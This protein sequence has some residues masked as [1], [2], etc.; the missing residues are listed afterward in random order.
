MDPPVNP[1]QGT[2]P[3]QRTPPRPPLPVT[4]TTPTTL[5]HIDPFSPTAPTRS[6]N[7][8]IH[9]SPAIVTTSTPESSQ[10]GK[11]NAALIAQNISKR[12]R[13]LVRPNYKA[14]SGIRPKQTN[15]K[16]TDLIPEILQEE[17]E[18]T[19]RLTFPD[20]RARAVSL[21]KQSGADQNTLQLL[22]S[23][24]QIGNEDPEEIGEEAGQVF[25]NRHD[26]TQLIVE[27]QELIVALRDERQQSIETGVPSTKVSQLRD[28]IDHNTET[29]TL[30]QNL[31]LSHLDLEEQRLRQT[32]SDATEINETLIETDPNLSQT[33]GFS[34]KQIETLRQTAGSFFAVTP[35]EKEDFG[36]II[37]PTHTHNPA[38][39]RCPIQT[40]NL[41]SC[42]SSP[43]VE[44]INLLPVPKPRPNLRFKVSPV[45]TASTTH[46]VVSSY[47]SIPRNTAS[48]TVPTSSAI[49]TT[50][51]TFSSTC[52][53]TT[54]FAAT[55][56]PVNTI[57]VNSTETFSST[58]PHF[59]PVFTKTKSVPHSTHSS[60][61][62][63]STTDQRSSRATTTSATGPPLIPTSQ[64]L[65]PRP[66]HRATSAI[67]PPPTAVQQKQ[68]E[69]P[70]MAELN[71]TR[72]ERDRLIASLMSTG[73]TFEYAQRT[74]DVVYSS[75][76]PTP[77][78]TLG[79]FIDHNQH[80]QLQHQAIALLNNVPAFS[81]AMGTRFEDWVRHFE[82]CT[83]LADF[84]ESRK[85]LILQSK[86]TS[87][88]AD[89][90]QQF[91]KQD[92]VN[93]ESFLK[94][95][96]CLH[97]R[98]HGNETH[99]HYAE[100][101]A[102]CVRLDK[103]S[104]RDYASRLTKIFQYC[105]PEF[106][107]DSSSKPS[108]FM[109]TLLMDKFRAGLQHK[110]RKRISTKKFSS[111]E[112]MIE[113]VEGHLM[114]ENRE[115]EERQAE[116]FIRSVQGRP[117]LSTYPAP[118]PIQQLDTQAN[119][120][121]KREI[122]EMRVLIQRTLIELRNPLPASDDRRPGPGK[123]K[124]RTFPYDAKLFCSH[125]QMNGHDI[126]QCQAKNRLCENC[127]IV[128]H[129]RSK[130]PLRNQVPTVTTTSA[131]LL[132]LPVPRSGN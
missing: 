30:L 117:A 131:P 43:L 85:I 1:F 37:P 99:T 63:S 121:L 44:P 87:T 109:D 100:Q 113:C 13:S 132:P 27:Q 80:Q 103:E 111:M 93:A 76:Q 48:S 82:A 21:L 125:C 127:N 112:K 35:T 24:D 59:R 36:L 110:L 58:I 22:H 74:A 56:I 108:Q 118:A 77:L 8:S 98:F 81:G 57:P 88:A 129:F 9:S 6:L 102:K 11:S 70:K 96:E 105:Y 89:T 47:D 38:D 119:Q 62:Q 91:Q 67:L 45:T 130:C 75:K 52:P 71:D 12:L 66:V 51:S 73:V 83:A 5:Q 28:L 15:K 101:F 79:T 34:D 53:P 114:E 2:N 94:I 50:T 122:E 115:E 19:P 25:F 10:I 107:D 26:L 106:Y 97:K 116:V 39:S 49:P 69:L 42:P 60:Q 126:A 46:T 41:I 124:R 68:K 64:Q 18:H 20:D 61:Q 54:F 72:T 23:L 90:F 32:E 3:V 95:K 29:I 55:A 128:G 65:A 16:R 40:T 120:D 123:D 92:Q 33:H 4:P 86:L 84:E 104:V 14:L 78:E 17:T 31:R 7:P